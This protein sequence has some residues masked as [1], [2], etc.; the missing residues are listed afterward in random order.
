MR[1]DWGCGHPDPAL[2][3]I[4]NRACSAFDEE[5]VDQ[6]QRLFA[7]RGQRVRRTAVYARLRE[8]NYCRQPRKGKNPRHYY[9]TRPGCRTSLIIAECPE[10]R[11]METRDAASTAI[12]LSDLSCREHQVLSGLYW[13]GMTMKDL[14]I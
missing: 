10:L 11:Q 8:Q 12:L 13:D 3:Q 2:L 7:L 4:E 5:D 6:E 9:M 1:V 14:Q